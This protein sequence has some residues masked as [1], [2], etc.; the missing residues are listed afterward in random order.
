MIGECLEKEVQ[1]TSVGMIEAE[2]RVEDRGG[3]GDDRKVNLDTS[4]GLTWIHEE[5]EDKG[6]SDRADVYGIDVHVD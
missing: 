2:R 4:L 3:E 6:G 5:E 1:G